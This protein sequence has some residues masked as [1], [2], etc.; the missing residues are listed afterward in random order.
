[1]WLAPPSRYLRNSL[2]VFIGQN[3]NERGQE[4]SSCFKGEEILRILDKANWKRIP[5]PSIYPKVS[6]IPNPTDG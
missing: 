3:Q 4:V 6:L 5:E 2:I 1:M